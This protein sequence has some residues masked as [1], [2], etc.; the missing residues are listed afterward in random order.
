MTSHKSPPKSL[1]EGEKIEDKGYDY[2]YDYDLKK[3]RWINISFLLIMFTTICFLL[4][5]S[6]K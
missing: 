1:M 5:R 2:F 3:V 4:I 6:L